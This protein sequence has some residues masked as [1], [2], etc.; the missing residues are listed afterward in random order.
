M[1]LSYYSLRVLLRVACKVVVLSLAISV[2]VV[3]V[4]PQFE[5]PEEAAYGP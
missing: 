1:Y 3:G 5:K 2:I 4:E